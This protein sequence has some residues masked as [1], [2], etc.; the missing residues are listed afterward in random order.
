[1]ICVMQRLHQVDLAGMLI[2]SGLWKELRLP[3]IATENQTI[4]LT[5][6]RRHFRREGDVLHPEREPLK[7]LEALRAAMGAYAY[8]A[9]YQQ[10]P[11]PLEGNIIKA[12][13]LQAYD[14][15]ALPLTPGMI[16]QSW[17]TANK[18]NA[19]CDYSVC[20]TALLRGTDIFILDVFRARLEFPDLKRKVI[21]LA[22]QHK[23]KALLIEDQASGTQLIQALR[24]DKPAGVPVPIMRKPETDKVSRAMGI[25]AMIE[26]G[27][28][29]LPTFAPWLAPFKSEVLAFPS[30]R[31][32]DQV[33]ALTQQLAW[34]QER[35]CVP[36]AF[37]ARPMV[38]TIPRQRPGYN[39]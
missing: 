14:L 27:R 10:D 38:F 34:I 22:L 39:F 13:W 2:E 28:L 4:P 21:A 18:I 35:D 33:D 26:A 5:R 24:A 37:I 31:H 19:D 30:G 8:A 32:K 16:I 11:V 20:I 25:S 12:Q 36:K 17:D 9:Q 3:A 29:Y 15:A 1:M 7:V 23:P 6:G